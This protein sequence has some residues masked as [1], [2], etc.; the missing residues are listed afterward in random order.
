MALHAKHQL[1]STSCNAPAVN[2]LRVVTAA[3]DAPG[4]NKTIYYKEHLPGPLLGLN[5]RRRP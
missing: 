2:Q 1:H 5:E 4:R 3:N